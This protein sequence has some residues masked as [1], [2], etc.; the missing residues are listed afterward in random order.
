[1]CYIY[2]DNFT[3]NCVCVLTNFTA[4]KVFPALDI[5]RIG[6]KHAT[7]SRHF[8]SQAAF[9][10]LLSTYLQSDSL[11]ANQMLTLRTIANLFNQPEG[12]KL[13]GENQTQVLQA[14]ATCAGVTTKNAQIAQSTAVLNF[15][16]AATALQDFERKSECLTSATQLL[17]SERDSE[18]TFRLL[19]ALGTLLHGDEMCQAVLHSLDFA[20]VLKKLRDSSDLNKVIECADLILKL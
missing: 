4:D 15:A 5:L 12:A 3:K 13:M 14:T 19:V 17:T 7:V 6:V 18:A 2:R 20:P 1:M 11:S 16:I 9:L 10:S 8:C